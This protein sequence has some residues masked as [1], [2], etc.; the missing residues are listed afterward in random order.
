[1]VQPANSHLDLSDVQTD[2]SYS[3][4]LIGV[5]EESLWTT[6]WG[7][8]CTFPLI[9]VGTFSTNPHLS[10]SAKM[11]PYIS[12][13][14]GASLSLW[15]PPLSDGK[16]GGKRSMI[17]F[18]W[19]LDSVPPSFSCVIE[20]F[21]SLVRKSARGFVWPSVTAASM[22]W[23]P[24]F[25]SGSPVKKVAAADIPGIKVSGKEGVDLNSPCSKMC[26]FFNKAHQCST[27]S[28]CVPLQSSV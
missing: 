6:W 18:P 1:M 9:E 13:S 2:E 23:L 5:V 8:L 7:M 12:N 17:L 25:P 3:H 20:D 22:L 11:F 26:I 10:C 27:L 19:E 28:C 24:L 16:I 21:R 15:V 4:K 14:S